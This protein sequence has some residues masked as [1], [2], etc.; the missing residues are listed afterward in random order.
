MAETSEPQRTPANES[1]SL[2]EPLTADS[3][4]HWRLASGDF[5]HASETPFIPVLLAE[6]AAA[7]ANLSHCLFGS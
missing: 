6:F 5:G 2:L 1:R 3:H 4:A 7:R